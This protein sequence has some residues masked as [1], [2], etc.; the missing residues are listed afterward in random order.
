MENLQLIKKSYFNLLAIFFE[1]ENITGHHVRCL[2]KWGSHLGISS[3]DIENI[4]KNLTQQK[5]EEPADEIEKLEWVY[6]LV[7]IYCHCRIRQTPRCR[8]KKRS[9]GFVKSPK[10]LI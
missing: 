4:G 3:H 6:H 10:K 2:F 1:R 7:Q 8:C 9:N 5:F